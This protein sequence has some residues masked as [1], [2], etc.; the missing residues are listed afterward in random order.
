MYILDTKQQLGRQD[1]RKHKLGKPKQVK[2][3]QNP[4]MAKQ[5][6]ANNAGWHKPSKIRPQ[7]RFNKKHHK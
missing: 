1:R 6:T 7:T 3:K 2:H 5:I 4:K